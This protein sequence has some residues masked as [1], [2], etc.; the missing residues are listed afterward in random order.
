MI[1]SKHGCSLPQSLLCMFSIHSEI[2]RDKIE[3]G[4]SNSLSRAKVVNITRF[5]GKSIAGIISKE[6]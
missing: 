2:V 1:I 5:R 6:A 3:Q 4:K